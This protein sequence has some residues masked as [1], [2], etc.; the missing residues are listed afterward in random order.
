[1][2]VYAY[3]FMYIYMYICFSIG[4]YTYSIYTLLVS[5]SNT[6]CVC[7]TAV[8]EPFRLNSYDDDDDDVYLEY[9]SGKGFHIN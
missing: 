4:A 1:V 9:Y 5:Y 3:V 2:Y 7:S 8:S 6:S